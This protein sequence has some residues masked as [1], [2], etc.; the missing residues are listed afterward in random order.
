[1]ALT[2]VGKEGV[3]GISN[4]SNA[5]AITIDSSE[6]VGIGVT[7]PST[8]SLGTAL[9]IGN[10]E[11]NLWGEADYAIHMSQNAYYNSGWKYSHT[12]EATRYSQE[13]GQ[14]IWSYAGSGSANAALTWSE[15]MRIDA[16]GRVTMPSQPAFQVHKNGTEQ[17]NIAADNSTVAVTFSTEA[18]DLG[19]NFASNTFTA[20]VTG[21]YLMALKLR[22]NNVDTASQYYIA[23]VITS[24]SEYHN[25]Y[26]SDDDAGGDLEYLTLQVT[27]LVDMDAN[28]TA[29][30]GVTQQGG[31]QQTDINGG[32]VYTSFSG[33]LVA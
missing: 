6:N 19:G 20:P 28:D 33:Y 24:N 22:F 16:S 3:T 11:N 4:S 31:T 9:H 26:D 13:D 27:Q 29:T 7:D 21:K 14:H 2:K 1:V 5:T 18:F 10:K 32:R 15:A 8:W 17:S 30:V 12:D 23:R 25:I